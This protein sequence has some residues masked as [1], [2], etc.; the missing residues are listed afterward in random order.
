[1]SPGSIMP[2]Y[3]HLA[4]DEL[5]LSLL[6]AKITAL[7]KLGTPYPEGFEDRA[8]ADAQAQAKKIAEKLKSE[9]VKDDGMETKEMMAI[10]AY[11]QRIGTDI[12]K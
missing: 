9:G 8:I 11:L 1:M 7:R 4:D 5:D 10:I 6:P 3:P 12:K 2:Q